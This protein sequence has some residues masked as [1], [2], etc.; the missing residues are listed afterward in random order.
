M[1]FILNLLKKTIL[2]VDSVEKLHQLL[3][4]T[5]NSLYHLL[6]VILAKYLETV[7]K[8]LLRRF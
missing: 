4:G 1:P 5:K 6:I 3:Q 8:Q 2:T 7:Y